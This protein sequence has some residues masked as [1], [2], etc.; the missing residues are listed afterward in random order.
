MNITILNLLAIIIIHVVKTHDVRTP[1][2]NGKIDENAE[3]P[4]YC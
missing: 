2:D 3:T 4:C 1:R